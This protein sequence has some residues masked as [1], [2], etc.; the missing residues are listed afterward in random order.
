MKIINCQQ[1]TD[2]WLNA[3]LGIMTASNAHL[4]L[5]NG[6]KDGLGDGLITHAYHLIAERFTGR[7]SGKFDG[8]EY[9]ERGHFLE[10]IV[11][12]YYVKMGYAT[13]S[14][15][16][17]VGIVLNFADKYGYP[18]GAS[19]DR[20]VGE[21]A[22]L[23]I[24]TREPHLQAKLLDTDD[25]GKEHLAQVQFNLWVTGREW[26][27]YIS[28][29]DGMPFFIKTYFPDRQMHALFDEKIGKFYQLIEQK[30]NKM[31]GAK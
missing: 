20:L 9:T 27:D 26:W 23:E 2:E 3:R 8:N 21:N 1:G 7:Q 28:Y 14:E 30:M 12:D 17:E 5:V 6:K 31:L 13:P 24:K 22:G 18:V 4:L 19:P 25:I 29:A 15:I 16:A 10:P 11:S